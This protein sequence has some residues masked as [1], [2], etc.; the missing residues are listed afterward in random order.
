MKPKIPKLSKLIE[1]RP[2]VVKIIFERDDEYVTKYVTKEAYPCEWWDKANRY[3][4]NPTLYNRVNRLRK[5]CVKVTLPR[6]KG[7]EFL[8]WCESIPGWNS[9]PHYARWAMFISVAYKDGTWDDI[10]ALIEGKSS[11]SPKG[12][13]IVVCVGGRVAG[14]F[15]TDIAKERIEAYGKKWGKKLNDKWH[16]EIWSIQ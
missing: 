12:D 16:A 6:E 7:L 10:D 3:A 8:R 5:Y 4:W 13:V 9:G 1:Q 2:D 11:L 15:S 14:V